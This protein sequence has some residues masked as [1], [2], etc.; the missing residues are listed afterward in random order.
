MSDRRLAMRAELDQLEA[1]IRDAPGLPGWIARR[2]LA[3][4]WPLREC[5]RL[6]RWL[7]RLVEAHR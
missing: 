3:E 2:G 4:R 7:T 5:D 1:E 6:D